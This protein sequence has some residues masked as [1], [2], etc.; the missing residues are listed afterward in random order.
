MDFF[1]GGNDHKS[2]RNKEVTAVRDQSNIQV[3]TS[4]GQIATEYEGRGHPMN[5]KIIG[6]TRALAA[7][8][9]GGVLAVAAGAVAEGSKLQSPNS[10]NVYVTRM[11]RCPYYPS[12]VVCHSG[13][14]RGGWRKPLPHYNEN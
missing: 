9:T 12:P 8:I 10:S 1:F 11:D 5:T 14:Y 4:A 2:V 6:I 7:T 13:P 3:S